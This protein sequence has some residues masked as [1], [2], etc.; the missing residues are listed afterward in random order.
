MTV[1]AQLMSPEKTSNIT[2]F[3][4][5]NVIFH[6]KFKKDKNILA[7]ILN[8]NSLFSQK[9]L[10]YIYNMYTKIG[11]CKIPRKLPISQKAAR[12]MACVSQP[13]NRLGPYESPMIL[14]L[15]ILNADINH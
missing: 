3:F 9:C 11:K 8:T 7:I 14:Q 5:E 13:L 12:L 4:G 1:K 6:R 15:S 10:K 2:V